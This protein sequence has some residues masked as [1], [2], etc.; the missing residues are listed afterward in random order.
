[1]KN[2]P[3]KLVA[4]LK[5]NGRYYTPALLP[6]GIPRGSVGDCYDNC[7][8]NALKKKFF[9]VE[10]MALEP[11]TTDQWILHAWLTDAQFGKMAFDPTWRA[12]SFDNTTEIEIPVPTKYV[13]MSMEIEDVAEFMLSTRY[14]GIF[15]NAWRNPELAEKCCDGIPTKKL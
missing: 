14:A 1:M 2:V 3:D 13:G 8:V 12:M 15:A 7:A 4:W 9:Y 6:D 5:R 10:G 11:G